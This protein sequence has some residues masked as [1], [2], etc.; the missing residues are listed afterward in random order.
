M[1][2]GGRRTDCS[3]SG[4]AGLGERRGHPV[5]G[6]TRRRQRFGRNG[7]RQVEVRLA[8]LGARALVR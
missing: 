4:A 2:N 1:M 3:P 5:C 8:V 7:D 6:L